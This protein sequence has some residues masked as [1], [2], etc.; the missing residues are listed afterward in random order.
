MKREQHDKHKNLQIGSEEFLKLCGERFTEVIDR[1]QVYD[2]VLARSANMRS[3]DTGMKMATA[4]MAEP[5]VSANMAADARVDN[6]TGIINKSMALFKKGSTFLSASVV[7]QQPSAIVRATAMVDS[8]HFQWAK[9]PGKWAL[10]L[11]LRRKQHDRLWAEVKQYAPVA[12]I[13]EMGYFD[14]SV[15]RSTRDFIQA[16]EYT[17]FDEKMKGLIHD[18]GYLTCI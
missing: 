10:D 15:G 4:F 8:K 17:T 6:T 14:T 5:T 1:T 18:S 7:I 11:G 13:K 2:S 3:K 16:Q 12:L 9:L